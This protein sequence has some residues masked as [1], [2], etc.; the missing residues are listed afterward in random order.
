MVGYTPQQTLAGTND[1]AS[2]TLPAIAV[3]NLLNDPS[4][5]QSGK[6]VENIGESLSIDPWAIPVSV[7][8]DG[9]RSGNVDCIGS[10]IEPVVHQVTQD[11]FHGQLEGL[12]IMLLSCAFA[13]TT[14]SFEALNV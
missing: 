8:E 4:E 7:P 10:L 6:L 9:V 5:L 11:G 12:L 13:K 2:G 3:A 1:R 14:P